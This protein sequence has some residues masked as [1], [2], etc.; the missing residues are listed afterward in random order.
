MARRGRRID[1]PLT[2]VAPGHQAGQWVGDGIQLAGSASGKTSPPGAQLPLDHL[3]DTPQQVTHAHGRP[4]PTHVLNARLVAASSASHQDR[5][6]SPMA[7]PPPDEADEATRD[8]QDAKHAKRVW[9]SIQGLY[10][11]EEPLLPAEAG[12]I[13]E[14]ELDEIDPIVSGVNDLSLLVNLIANGQWEEVLEAE[15]EA[16]QE[17]PTP[18]SAADDDH[19]GS[20]P[21]TGGARGQRCAAWYPFKSKMV[22]A[23][24][25]Q[26]LTPAPLTHR[27]A[28][29][30]A[31]QEL[32]GSLIMGHTH[33]LISC[34]V[35]SKIRA[36]LTS[37]NVNLPA[38]ATI[39]A[40]RKRIRTL[41]DSQIS[42]SS[43]PFGTPTF[44]LRP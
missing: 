26:T 43:S 36:I 4:K 27:V 23:R 24:V 40:S 42:Y 41:L 11:K 14:Q 32:V 28:H 29:A 10:D 44:A 35:Y 18:L 7:A 33:S 9:D 12:R 6:T 31:Y 3:T 5:Q 8:A 38:W 37:C 17:G 30:L 19:Q 16:L 21:Q 25:S 22:R 2:E 13:L 20:Q 39:Q 34:S 1:A 15:L